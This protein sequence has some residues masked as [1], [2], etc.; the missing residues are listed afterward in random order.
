MANKDLKMMLSELIRM[1]KWA[2]KNNYQIICD[3]ITSKWGAAKN[4]DR[5]LSITPLFDKM[6]DLQACMIQ[7]MYKS[8]AK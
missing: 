1:R 2:K 5:S 8:M 7:E 4:G 6:E 3:N